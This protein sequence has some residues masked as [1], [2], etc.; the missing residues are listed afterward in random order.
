MLHKANV[1][2]IDEP[3]NHLDL[4]SKGVLESALMNYEGTLFFISHDRYFLNKLADKMMELSP[5]GAIEYN[6]NY[7]NY[8]EAKSQNRKK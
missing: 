5:T 2:I 1:L 7:D 8:V 3:T 6:G 4:F